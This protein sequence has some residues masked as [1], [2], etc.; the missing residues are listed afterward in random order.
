MAAA[1][2]AAKSAVCFKSVVLFCVHVRAFL[3][4]CCKE[5]STKELHVNWTCHETHNNNLEIIYLR[6][7][8]GVVLVHFIMP[9]PKG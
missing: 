6:A 8:S 2:R 4:K 9:P 1:R 5:M 7:V 3:R